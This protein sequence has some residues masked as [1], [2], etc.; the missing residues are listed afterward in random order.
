MF[1]SLPH[2][3]M[4]APFVNRVI[5]FGQTYTI[6]LPLDFQL[7]G[8]DFPLE[9]EADFEATLSIGWSFTLAFGFDE[10]SGFFINTFP[11]EASEFS[12]EGLLTVSATD[13]AARLLFLNAEIEE[14]T[15]DF[16]AGLYIDLDKQNGLGLDTEE[17]PGEEYGRLTKTNLSQIPNKKNIL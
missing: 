10:T 4:F 5:P 6:D 1:G 3:F 8:G 13:I 16:G 14:T 2:S 17:D 15:I 11:G 12:V 7:G 9:V